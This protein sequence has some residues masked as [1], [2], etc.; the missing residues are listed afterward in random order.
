MILGSFLTFYILLVKLV[1][2]ISTTKLHLKFDDPGNDFRKFL[3]NR[4]Y[5]ISDYDSHYSRR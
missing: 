4:S 1:V 2:Y 3:M 5:Y